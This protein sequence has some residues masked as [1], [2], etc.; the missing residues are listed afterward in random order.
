MR[1]VAAAGIA[2]GAAAFI[3]CSESTGSGGNCGSG[4]PPSVVGTYK[5]ARYTLGAN[6]VDTTQGASG[7]LRFYAAN[8][9]FNA[10][11]PV[12]GAVVDSGSYTIT[13]IR[14]MSE[15]SVLNP[16]TSSGEFT[17]SGTTPGSVFTFA[18]TNTIV[19]PVG[20]IAVKQ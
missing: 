16:G 11:I 5:L 1:S 2:L 7:Q 18:G 10:T 20:F 15:V 4:T 14:C 19:G 9:A 12:T 17:L 8:Y 3:G 6:T 13:G